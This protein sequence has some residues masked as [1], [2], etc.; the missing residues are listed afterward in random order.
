MQLTLKDLIDAGV[1]SGTGVVK[2]TSLPSNVTCKPQEALL[3]QLNIILKAK[4]AK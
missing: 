1:N 4:E 3:R 2:V